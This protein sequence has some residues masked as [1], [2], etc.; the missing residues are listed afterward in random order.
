MAMDNELRTNYA[1]EIFHP[2]SPSIIVCAEN[3]TEYDTWVIE[4]QKAIEKCIKYRGNQLTS[5]MLLT[6]DL[7]QLSLNPDEQYSVTEITVQV[8]QD[9][10]KG[11]RVPIYQ[12][13]LHKRGWK[14]TNWKKRFFLL[15]KNVLF[16]YKDKYVRLQHSS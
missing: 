10:C 9:E 7:Y 2:L 11:V 14:R 13:E 8:E 5:S 6:N 4:L 12:G 15:R 1:F 3:R 16:Y